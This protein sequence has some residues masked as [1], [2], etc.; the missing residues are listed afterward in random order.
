[1]MFGITSWTDVNFITSFN[2]QST[3]FTGVTGRSY[4]LSDVLVYGR[5][6]RCPFG[7]FLE[8]SIFQDIIVEPDG[9]LDILY[10]R[11]A[12]ELDQS[13]RIVAVNSN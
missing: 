3:F 2:C 10:N 5:D 8:K 4:G 13:G 11:R 1:M 12:L 9:N 7:T 6:C